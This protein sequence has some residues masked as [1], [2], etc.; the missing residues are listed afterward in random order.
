MIS[1]ADGRTTLLKMI[2]PALLPPK[3]RAELPLMPLTPSIFQVHLGVDM[4]LT[5]YRDKVERLNFVYPHD[6]IERAMQHFPNGEYEKAAYFAYIATLHQSE[7]APTGRHSMKL[8]SYTTLRTKGIDWQR[9]ADTIARSFVQRTNALI[10]GLS[11]HIVTQAVRTPLDLAADTGNSR[12]PSRLGIHPRTAQQGAPAAAHPCARPLPGGALD[13][14][15]SGRA[16]GDAVRLQHREHRPQRLV[17]P[18]PLTAKALTS[19]KTGACSM[20]DRKGD[21]FSRLGAFVTRRGWWVVVLWLIAAGGFGAFAGKAQTSLQGAG[22]DVS[23]SESQVVER[24]LDEAFHDSAT[25]NAVIVYSAD[26]KATSASFAKKASAVD[27]KLRKV[28]GVAK[29]RSYYTDGDQMLL[30]KDEHTAITVVS[31]SGGQSEAQNKVPDLRKQTEGAGID[32]KVTGFPAVQ[33]DTYKLSQ[34]DLAKTEM[35]TFPVVAIFLLI[36]FRT[37]VAALVPLALGGSP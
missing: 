7:M 31:L 37:V 20:S 12:A 1:A 15:R 11:E 10:P 33:Y 16:V 14:A 21:R 9:D 28:P 36:F 32:V 29:V 3:L 34:D 8:E 4:D 2:D 13:D 18:Y 17:T 5:P 27:D 19:S 25:T 26:G 24:I 6:D 30:S 22:F 35:I 23:G